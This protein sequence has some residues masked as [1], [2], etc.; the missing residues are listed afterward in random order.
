MSK[1]KRE[2]AVEDVSEAA[3]NIAINSFSKQDEAESSSLNAYQ[4]L[5]DTISRARLPKR[6]RRV[7][8]VERDQQVRANTLAL[9]H[10]RQFS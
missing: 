1:R 5:V 10:E 7:P 8:N 2:E 4:T 9:V 3:Y 6:R